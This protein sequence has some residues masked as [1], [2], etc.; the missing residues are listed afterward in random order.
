[1]LVALLGNAVNLMA[2]II[3]PLAS[4]PPNVLAAIGTLM[5]PPG[6]N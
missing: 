4:V 1:M 2:V 6:F 3:P 5:V